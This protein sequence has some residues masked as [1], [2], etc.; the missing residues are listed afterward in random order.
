MNLFSKG[1]KTPELDDFDDIDEVLALDA[2]MMHAYERRIEVLEKLIALLALMEQNNQ[3]SLKIK[4]KLIER[5]HLEEKLREFYPQIVFLDTEQGV[6]EVGDAIFNNHPVVID[7]GATYGTSFP[8]GIREL[9]AYVRKEQAPLAIVSLVCSQKDMLAWMDS[10]RLHPNLVKAIDAGLLDLIEGIA[11]IRFPVT[12]AA[13]EELGEYYVNGD[14]EV[15]VF[16]VDNDPLMEYLAKKHHIRYIGVRSSNITG[17]P[18]EPFATGAQNYAHAIG[19]PLFAVRSRAALQAQLDDEQVTSPAEAAE[20]LKRKRVG[21]QPILTFT[22]KPDPSS[23]DQLKAV[24]ELVRTGNTNAK[25]IERL[26]KKFLKEYKI[27]FD[28]HEEKKISFQRRLFDVPE[29]ITDPQEIKQAILDA[30]LL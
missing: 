15:Q 19:A 29:K 7:Y 17:Q 21:S 16:M 5:K 23:P 4:T 30:T 3:V 25:T 6:Q 18:E 22:Q 28:H 2:K 13:K 12:Q 27:G 1:Q 24:I 26:L 10:D 9:V 14:N 11:F 20:K 8:A